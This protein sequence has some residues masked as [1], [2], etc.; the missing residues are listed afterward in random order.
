MHNCISWIRFKWQSC[1]ASH[2]CMHLIIHSQTLNSLVPQVS[3]K[4]PV[5]SSE[6]SVIETIKHSTKVLMGHPGDR[7]S[8]HL[9]FLHHSTQTV[10]DECKK[11]T[12]LTH[13]GGA[14]FLLSPATALFI[15]LL[16]YCVLH[17]DWLS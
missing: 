14:C 8:Y 12:R 13:F 16:H 10:A 15:L 7:D 1:E 2:F 11:C 17:S 5:P 3:D 9:F 4:Q 6:N